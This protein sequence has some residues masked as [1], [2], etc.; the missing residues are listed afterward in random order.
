MSKASWFAHGK[1]LLYGDIAESC[2][3][4]AEF[5]TEADCKRAALAL[6]AGDVMARRKIDKQ[7]G[8][9]DMGGWIMY[10]D[11]VDRQWHVDTRK[12]AVR[13]GE[14]SYAGGSHYFHDEDPFAALVEADQW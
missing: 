10:Y 6:N 8:C 2:A 4:A 7:C 13:V 12:G 3:V 11:P 14:Q 9:C 5:S 1:Q